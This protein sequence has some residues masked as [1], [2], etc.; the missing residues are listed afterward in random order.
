MFRFIAAIL[1]LI[2]Q[3]LLSEPA[4]AQQQ[5][6]V[7]SQPAQN[8]KI[9][10]TGGFVEAHGIRE[11]LA[12]EA[13]VGTIWIS[14]AVD[15]SNLQIEIRGTKITLFPLTNGL[16]SIKW[17][18]TDTDLLHD[19]DILSLSGKDSLKNVETWAAKID[20]PKAGPSTL[21]LF[22]FDERSFG[23]FLISKPSEAKIVRQME[24]H[25]MHGRRQRA[26]EDTSS[27]W[28]EHRR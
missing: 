9:V 23:G 7:N 8:F 14:T 10:N 25:Q 1:V 27:T 24:F 26:D 18:S 2:Y 16:A 22:K 11:R 20:W 17:D 13:E 15:N 19:Q 3:P 12:P 6:P 21:V 4:L 5:T 28:P